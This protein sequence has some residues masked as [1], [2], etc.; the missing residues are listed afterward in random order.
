MKA[1]H[2]GT[3]QI[4]ECIQKA[5]AKSNRL[6]AHGYTLAY[7]WQAGTCDGSGELPL[8]VTKDFA[9]AVLAACKVAVANFV[10]TNCPQRTVASRWEKDPAINAWHSAQQA[11]SGR[12]QYIAWTEQ[13]LAKWAP[14]TQATVQEIETAETSAKATRTGIRALSGAEKLAK[15]DLVKFGEKFKGALET[16][17]NGELYAERTAFYANNNNTGNFPRWNEI[18]DIPWF[19]TNRVSSYVKLAAKSG[20]AEVIAGAAKLQELSG[21]YEAAKAAHKAAKA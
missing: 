11:Q 14:R 21:I 15:H 1:T 16:A 2:Y 19:A 8:E 4:C 17:L 18:I 5:D 3:C 6:A 7:G 20:D 10:A 13:R 12:K 9:M